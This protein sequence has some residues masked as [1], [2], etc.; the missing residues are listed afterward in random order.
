MKGFKQKHQDAASHEVH[1]DTVSRGMSTVFE[2]FEAQQPQCGFCKKGLSCQLCSDGPCRI[3]AK[4]P[5]GVC[6]ASGDVIVARNLLQ[7]AIMGTAANTYQCRNLANTLKAIGEG[8]S[9][10]SLKDPVKLQR[11]C[12]GLGIDHTK[13]VNELAV[14]FGDFVLGE[15]NKPTHQP[16]T[17]MDYFSLDSRKEAWKREG[18]YTGGPANEIITALSKCMTNVS[19]DPVDLLKTAL[20]L[21]L[22]NEYVALWGITVMQ[23]IIMGTAD[24]VPGESNIGCL[25]PK[26]VNIVANGHQ[27]VF[28]SLLIEKAG[29][30]KFQAAAKKAGAKGIK[31]YGSLC[32]GQQL[33]NVSSR[34]EYKNVFGGQLGNWIQEELFI[35]TGVVDVF[36]MDLNCSLPSLKEFADTYG[37]KL[38]TTDPVVRFAGVQNID[39]NPEIAD[40]QAESI[41]EAAIKTFKARKKAKREPALPSGNGKNACIGGYTTETVLKKFGY[42]I[43]NYIEE[44]KKGNIKGAV[45]VAGCT[46]VRHGQGGK[47]IH[48]LTLEL[49]KRNIMV[50][51]AGC[52]SSTH[53][54][55]AM[56]T[57]EMA[58][59]AGPGLRSVC[60]A[61]D[62]PPVI[63]YGSCTDVGKIL[64][65]VSALAWTLGCDTSQLPVA[66]AV[67]EYME[68]KA[69]AD[70]FTA[71]A[72]GLLTHV[73]PEPR[74]GGSPLVVDYLTKDMVK[75]TGGRLLL[76]DDP[77]KAADAIEAHIMAKRKALRFG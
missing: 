7:L 2:R 11:M 61:Y 63:S 18:I 41:L 71:L 29:S 38:I 55:N 56:S 53:Q 20:R 27:P 58:K 17:L 5:L 54:N 8:K 32:E 26:T 15:I 51:G 68:Q 13:P 1:R 16:L 33:M 4:A 77:V 43:N 44:V 73:S 62:M 76:E 65:T 12:Q 67:P 40:E 57:M 34:D 69:I 28:A 36:L 23:D 59:L 66:A 64:D 49:I 50:I 37:T 3:S 19:N 75:V 70:I 42:D 74:I 9:S 10:L 6:G 47:A 52:C 30:E 35:A 22:S 21:G 60:E 14:A 46:T 31:V 45:A 72:F 39:F 24:L 25:D 48:D